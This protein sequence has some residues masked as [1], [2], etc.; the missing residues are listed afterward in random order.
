MH[1]LPHSFLKRAMAILIFSIRS[2]GKK[3]GTRVP[4]SSPELF[5]LFTMRR[6]L[7]QVTV[8][9]S[10]SYKC[11][12]TS[13]SSIST[14]DRSSQ[15]NPEHSKNRDMAGVASLIME[16]PS[17]LH[18]RACQLQMRLQLV[19][20]K[21]SQR[22]SNN[23]HLNMPLCEERATIDTFSSVIQTNYFPQYRQQ[24]ILIQAKGI[25]MIYMIT[26]YDN[27]IICFR[28][29]YQKT[30]DPSPSRLPP[31]TRITKSVQQITKGCF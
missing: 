13:I 22:W 28:V 20:A 30:E 8:S 9:H 11:K 17:F 21:P 14:S 29:E 26:I 19:W 18:E 16:K 1:K 10:H 7:P 27:S 3:Y 23:M 2:K 24:H 5:L 25:Y 6:V 4:R 12:I 31:P 15:V